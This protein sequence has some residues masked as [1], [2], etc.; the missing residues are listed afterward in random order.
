MQ[1]GFY[2]RVEAEAAFNAPTRPLKPL[3]QVEFEQDA[4]QPCPRFRVEIPKFYP[5]WPRLVA[6]NRAPPSTCR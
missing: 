3:K 1:V 6:T 4:S 2:L 5:A